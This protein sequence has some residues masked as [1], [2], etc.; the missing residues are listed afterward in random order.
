M[1]KEEEKNY[2][3]LKQITLDYIE[4]ILRKTGSNKA[5]TARILDVTVKTVH[6]QIENL[7]KH[8]P[9]F[10][11][12]ESNIRLNEK[13]TKQQIDRFKAK[14]KEPVRISRSV[15][16]LRSDSHL[17]DDPEYFPMPSNEERLRYADQ[18]VNADRPF[19]IIKSDED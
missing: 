3:T 17:S 18:L 6:N 4:Y 19:K 7:F 2:P 15:Y 1:E 13:R 8:S 12:Y 10:K 5:Q 11:L 14:L 9:E 16:Q